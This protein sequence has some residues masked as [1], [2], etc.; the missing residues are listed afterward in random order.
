[1]VPKSYLEGRGCEVDPATGRVW[2][3]CE[4]DGARI[5]L[6]DP[7]DT[8]AYAMTQAEF[9]IFS[10]ELSESIAAEEVVEVSNF[11]TNQTSDTLH[12]E[13]E[14]TLQVLKKYLFKN[15]LSIIE[16]L[17]GD[18]L[19]ELSENLA[20]LEALKIK[21]QFAPNPFLAFQL[22]VAQILEKTPELLV[23]LGVIHNPLPHAM[24]K[25]V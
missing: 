22:E 4:P 12:P 6:D 7:I 24:P 9:A 16:W 20:W 14:K 2:G 13:L 11:L 8:M 25:A 19:Q 15:V 23:E 3:P 18:Y 17:A 1:M 21:L 10:A 5:Y